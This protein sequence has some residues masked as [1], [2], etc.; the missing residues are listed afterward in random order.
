[1]KHFYN[2]IKINT[3]VWQKILFVNTYI[4]YSVRN[5]LSFNTIKEQKLIKNGG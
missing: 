4:N 5:C 1:M 2:N 3:F